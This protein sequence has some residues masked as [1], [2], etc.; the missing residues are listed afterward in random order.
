MYPIFF[1]KVIDIFP[2]LWY[3]NCV[4][5]GREHQGER[6]KKLEKSLKKLLTNSP[7]Y[8]IIEMFQGREMRKRLM[9]ISKCPKKNQAKWKN[10]WKTP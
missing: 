10:P 4:R 5:R 7:L 2:N 1:Q 6:P 9:A 8:D 3:Y